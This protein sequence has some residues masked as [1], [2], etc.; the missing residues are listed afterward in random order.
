MGKGKP[1]SKTTFLREIE[2]KRRTG[3][4]LALSG[5]GYR[6]SLYHLGLLRRLNE[7]GLLSQVDAISSVSGGS[8][9]NAVLAKTVDR[10]KSGQLDRPEWDR[11]IRDPLANF[12]RNN[13]RTWPILKSLMQFWK[14]GVA[15]SEIEKAYYQLLTDQTLG[16]LS[17]EVDFIFCASD[18]V[19]STMWYY[20]AKT[21]A[22]RRTGNYRAGWVKEWKTIPVARAVAASSCFPPIFGP[23]H[24]GYQPEEMVRPGNAHPT[25]E[26][27]IPKLRLTDGG[28]YDNLGLQPVWDAYQKLI[29]SDGGTPLVF[30]ATEGPLQLK[31][32]TDVIQGQVS[33]LRRRMLIE[34]D[35]N[36][37]IDFRGCYLGLHQGA[38]PMGYSQPFI[39]QV[40]I[41]VRTDLD[42]FSET[43]ARVLEN[44]SYTLADHY[45]R[46]YLLD[47]K[48]AGLSIDHDALARPSPPYPEE[49]NEDR[50][51]ETMRD[52][53]KRTFLFFLR[54]AWI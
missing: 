9:T 34:R 25:W 54:P 26:T 6:A 32:Y 53:H 44:H 2:V 40:L 43:E 28:V 13:I 42:C 22:N 17:S 39:D 38:L 8:I 35:Q 10:W 37:A 30:K 12:C 1:V 33:G 24:G 19:F 52:S 51:R 4:A 27:L 47:P 18:L 49:M 36:P 21:S 31:R 48:N 46:K 16:D 11:M 29:C 23:Q 7:I 15:V 3:L 50:V 45:L 20:R 5:G 41:N 14:N